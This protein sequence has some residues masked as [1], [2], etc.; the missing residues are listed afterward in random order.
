[1][2]CKM[3]FGYP[4]S[5]TETNWLHEC[6][7]QILQ[8]IHTCLETGN[9]VPVWPDILPE[10]YRD[11]L[12]RRK[13]LRDKLV[14]YEKAVAK[15]SSKKRKQ[16]LQALNDQNEIALLLSC[17][18]NCEAINDLPKTIRKPVIDLFAYA[19][20]ILTDLGIR[21][22]QYKAIYEVIPTKVCPFCG[23]EPFKSLGSRREALDHYLLESKYPF[24]ASNLR[25]LV[26]MCHTCNSGYKLSQD[27]LHRNND[28]RRKS[29]DPYNCTGIKLSLENS[30]PF[31]GTLTPI[32][33]L[34]QW[35]IQ[36]DP[37]TEEVLTWDEVFHIRE[38]YEKDVLDAE[39]KT[40]LEDFNSWCKS[41]GILP[42]S[43]QELLD[44][45]NR[46]AT[47]YEQ[48]G[49]SERAFLKASVF[50]M[51]HNHCQLGNRELISF[52]MSRVN[53]GEIS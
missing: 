10:M 3:L 13:A 29:F 5:A 23:C 15:L 8:L 37:N 33:Q 44:A 31:A 46:Y 50:R 7:R 32:G 20:D 21:D 38:R 19:F 17:Q 18:H 11:R 53:S 14:V 39:F 4:I 28:T 22:T 36:F 42:N 24:A 1:M 35:Q 27:M 52:L 6:L 49:F 41:A 48:M 47:L 16:I 51:L 34:P 26:P 40:W 25:N 30:Q 12:Q 2:G 43:N 45:L 9:Q